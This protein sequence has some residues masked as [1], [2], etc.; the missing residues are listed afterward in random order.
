MYQSIK[1]TLTAAKI[2][3]AT[4]ASVN[5]SIN[6]SVK[7]LNNQNQ[8][9]NQATDS[10]EFTIADTALQLVF[11]KPL[12]RAPPAAGIRVACWTEVQVSALGSALC[13]S[14]WS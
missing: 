7:Q 14:S 6:K 9:H 8:S 10:K 1:K 2:T 4:S 12:C 5:Q 13:L 3:G 11:K